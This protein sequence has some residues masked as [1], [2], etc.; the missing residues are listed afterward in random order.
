MG[1][2]SFFRSSKNAST[3][4][5]DWD[6]VDTELLFRFSALQRA[7]EKRC[8]TL[9]DVGNEVNETKLF[10]YITWEL[11]E[12]ILELNRHLVPEN[13]SDL[14]MIFFEWEGGD[15][16]Y[17]LEF[18]TG[19]E[20]VNVLS[21]DYSHLTTNV[22]RLPFDEVLELYKKIFEDIINLPIYEWKTEAL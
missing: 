13:D 4:K 22:Q 7:Y 21:Y 3:C 20:L 5:I 18:Y 1:T 10:G 12:A 14:P 8:E 16:A 11:K 15:I 6:S 17:A 2:Y 9:E 19:T